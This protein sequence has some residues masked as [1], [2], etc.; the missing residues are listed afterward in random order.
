[1]PQAISLRN[2]LLLLPALFILLC[3]LLTKIPGFFSDHSL[4]NAITLDLLLTTP[5]VYFLIIR[6]RSIPNTTVIP[7]II[8]GMVVATQIIPKSHQQLLR[9][10]IDWVFPIL[11]L[12][13]L[14]Y[15]LITIRKAIL[16]ART[17]KNHFLD[18]HDLAKGVASRIFPKRIAQLLA[19]EISTL[20]Y[21]LFSWQKHKPN[22]NEFTHYRS[23][24]SRLLL[25][26][27]IFLILV[28][29][30]ALHLLLQS[31]NTSVAWIVTG[32]SLYTCL[33]V[34]AI[35]KSLP[36]RPILLDDNVLRLRWGLMNQSEIP[37]NTISS[38]QLEKKEIEK[39]PGT[40]YLS[41]LHSAEGNNVVITLSKPTA[42]DQMYGFTK[43][44][45]K[46]VLYIDD[47]ER[48][49]DHPYFTK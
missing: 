3:I 30:G 14:A 26:V 37:L 4:S 16:V 39:T 13:V 34:L 48:F 20:Y 17:E 5:L 29:A 18:F 9:W 32:I 12:G 44:F 22:I 35:A 27:F 46:I 1:M 49:I 25:H 31:W 19:T 33:Q 6:K 36:N 2:L 24:S 28:E 47:P 43:P 41:P 7:I 8:L 21:A 40:A 11:E 45:S 10:F 23:T 38:I 42:M 15:M